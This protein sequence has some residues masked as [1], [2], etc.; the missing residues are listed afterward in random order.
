MLSN[1]AFEPHLFAT[2]MDSIYLNDEM[3]GIQR[4][5]AADGKSAKLVLVNATQSAKHPEVD[6][7]NGLTLD[8]GTPSR[9]RGHLKV[10]AKDVAQIDV[11]FDVSTASECLLHRSQCGRQ[12]AN[13]NYSSLCGQ[14]KLTRYPDML[15][16]APQLVA[17]PPLNANAC[18]TEPGSA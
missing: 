11:T 4:N 6:A 9:M 10:D 17:P 2:T 3:C 13:H 1:T 12:S 5:I 16:V 7:A 14:G 8:T 18:T 15:I